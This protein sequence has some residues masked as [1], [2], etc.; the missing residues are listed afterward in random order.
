[1]GKRTMMRVGGL[2]AGLALAAQACGGRSPTSPSLGN[3]LAFTHSP[4]DPSA[5]TFITPLGNLNPPEHTLPTNHI[6]FYHPPTRLP[7]TAPAG[8]VIF[9]ARRGSDDAL[10]V[11]AATGV[12]YYLAHIFLD[13][14]IATGGEVSA[15]QY[16]GETNT[17]GAMD[18][19]VSNDAVTLF[20]VRPERYIGFTIHADSPLKYFQEPARSTLYAKVR[21]NGADKDGKIDFDQPGRLAGNWFREGLAV[22][23]TENFAS[24]AQQLAF[25]RDVAE[26]AFVRVSIGGSLSLPGGF[27]IADGVPDPADVTPATGKVAYR[28]YNNALR[29]GAGNGLLI[30]QMLGDDRIQIE[31]FPGSTATTAEFTGASLIYVR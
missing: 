16:V 9:E 20:F 25:V 2:A 4:I 3:S 24:G 13:G 1:M 18:L 11:Q 23:D 27:W 28:L 30:V 26:P 31:T 22:A 5:I 15:G 6:Y 10:Y 8:G 14:S 7:V 17:T 21:R 12:L 19:G 29:I